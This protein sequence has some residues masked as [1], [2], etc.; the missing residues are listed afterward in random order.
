MEGERNGGTEG[1]RER[2]TREGGTK[3][4]Q[5]KNERG[6]E[7]GMEGQASS[8]KERGRDRVIQQKGEREG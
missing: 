6:S 7:G 8:R 3:R 2:G 5:L 4:H 1:W